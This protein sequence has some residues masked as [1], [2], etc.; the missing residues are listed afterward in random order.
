[1]KYKLPKGSVISRYH[2]PSESW[3][4]GFRT[5]RD[6]YFDDEEDDMDYGLDGD[7]GTSSTNKWTWTI[8]IPKTDG[9]V[10]ICV[11]EE[12]MEKEGEQ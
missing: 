9:Y 12:D 6:S 8:T 4:C 2:L 5:T 1:M 11:Y 10:T 7:C 3:F